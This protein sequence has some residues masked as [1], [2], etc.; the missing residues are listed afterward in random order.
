MRRRALILI[1]CTVAAWLSLVPALTAQEQRQPVVGFL[2]S[3]LRTESAHVMAAFEQG[4]DE[5]GYSNGRNVTIEYHFAQG[6]Y[7][8][9]PAMAA[10]L[11][12][13]R[14][15]VIVGQGGPMA[16]LA[17]KAATSTIPI[18][19]I[20]SGDPVEQGLVGNLGRPEGNA[21][22]VTQFAAALSAK[23]LE[24]LR[25]LVRAEGPVVALF[26]PNNPS[27]NSQ[28][29]DFQEAA[30]NIR[31]AVEIL[32]AR[33]ERE[34]A[35]AFASIARLSAKGLVVGGDSFFVSH[36]RL[37]AE[38]G[39]RHS[40]PAIFN[41]RLYAA[42]GG[43]VSYGTMFQ[44]VYRQAGVYAARVLR[45]AKPIELPVMLPARFELVINL[46]TAR[47]LGLTVT[48]SLLARADEVIE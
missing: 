23:R 31:Q 48:P 34:I 42:A 18:I 30:N 41:N 5:A 6:R 19:F 4:L 29:K 14:V 15:S 33:D 46:T 32:Y 3:G 37:L 8:Q 40:I 20:T 44:D 22:G 1:F 11:V 2:A 17:A 9:L 35:D 28:R 47:A 36:R 7:D 27:T 13:R 25:E 45:G 24:L 26:N 39:S 21:T 38:L 10:D 12:R 16:G 43:L